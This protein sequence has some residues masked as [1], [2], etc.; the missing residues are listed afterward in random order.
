MSFEVY[1]LYFHGLSLDSQGYSLIDLFLITHLLSIRGSSFLHHPN[2]FSMPLFGNVVRCAQCSANAVNL[3]NHVA[4]VKNMSSSLAFNLSFPRYHPFATL[5]I[6][7]GVG[8]AFNSSKCHQSKVSENLILGKDQVVGYI[9]SVEGIEDDKE[10]Q[11]RRKI[12]LANKGRVPWNKGK[13]H[14][15]GNCI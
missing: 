7:V 13:K 2:H 9:D 4:V 11:R 12:G 6:S 3:N 10:R 1:F 14:S 15:A 5:Q 8:D